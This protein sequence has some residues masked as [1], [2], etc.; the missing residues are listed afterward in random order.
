[1]SREMDTGSHAAAPADRARE[2][3]KKV[4][5]TAATEA[6]G[7]RNVNNKQIAVGIPSRANRSCLP[8]DRASGSF[9]QDC[10]P[11]RH[12][13]TTLLSFEDVDCSNN[14]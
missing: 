11:A 2:I 10:P 8:L 7:A 9:S 6:A 12:C 3:E 4:R 1:M 13:T 5:N 14:S